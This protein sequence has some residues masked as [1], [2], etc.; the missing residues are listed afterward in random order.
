MY[1]ET[2]KRALILENVAYVPDFHTN[3][4]S[5]F[6]LWKELK[7]WYF[8]HTSELVRGNPVKQEKIT[9]MIPLKPIY[10]QLVIEYKPL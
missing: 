5:G 3:I 9:L 10:R 6:L 1:G 7:I 4:V 2:K 8:P